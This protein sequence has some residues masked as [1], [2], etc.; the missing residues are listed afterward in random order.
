MKYT[1]VFTNAGGATLEVTNVQAS[2]GCTTAGEWTR[3]V[4][5]GMTGS[6][7]IQFSSVNFSGAVG[8][9][10]TVTCNDTN[11]P[12]VV[13]QIKGSDLEAH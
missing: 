9:S 4:E 10:I 3:Q 7:P 11:Q 12:A 6:I 8:K 5:P 2:C 13:L 1:Y